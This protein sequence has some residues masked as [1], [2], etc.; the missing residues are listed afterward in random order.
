MLQPTIWVVLPGSSRVANVTMWT[1]KVWVQNRSGTSKELHIV[2]VPADLP[3][4][5][6]R[7]NFLLQV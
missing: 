4:N 3:M 2:K 1:V 7:M 5:E 6:F